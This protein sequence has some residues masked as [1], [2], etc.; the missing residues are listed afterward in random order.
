ML[1]FIDLMCKKDHGSTIAST[2]VSKI[3]VQ[4]VPTIRTGDNQSAWSETLNDYQDTQTENN[5]SVSE[6]P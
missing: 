3:P 1:T 6:F 5:T 4:S 2:L